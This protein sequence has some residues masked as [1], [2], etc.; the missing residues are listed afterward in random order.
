MTRKRRSFTPEEFIQEAVCLVLDQGYTIAEASRSL[1]VDKSA[2][3]RWG[4]NHVGS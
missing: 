4:E 2:L 1:N 3:R